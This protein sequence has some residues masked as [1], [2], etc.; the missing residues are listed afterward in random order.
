MLTLPFPCPLPRSFPVDI[1]AIGCIMGELSDGQ[2]L[3]PGDSDIDQLY[4]IQ[5]ALGPVPAAMAHAFATN[6]R[7]RGLA[8]PSP[9]ADTSLPARFRGVMAPEALDLMSRSV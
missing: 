7:Y 2:P 6:A 4:V 5:R 9:E 8:M 3:F 1:W